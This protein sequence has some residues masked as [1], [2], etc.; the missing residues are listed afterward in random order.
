MIIDND[1]SSQLRNLGLALHAER[2]HMGCLR[3]RLDA[4]E[5]RYAL[6]I[7]LDPTPPAV[8]SRWDSPVLRL[9]TAMEDT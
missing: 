9:L 7:C 6:H 1:L 4:Y 3:S 8:T 2:T 5:C